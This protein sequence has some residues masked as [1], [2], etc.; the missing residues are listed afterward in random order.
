MKQQTFAMAADQGAGFERYRRRTKREDFLDAM[1]VIV[2]W[3]ALREVVEPHY[4]GGR[5]RPP[6]H[7]RQRMLALTWCSTGS[8]WP[9]RRGGGSGRHGSLRRFV[10]IDFGRER[11]PTRPRCCTSAACCES[12]S[13]AS[14]VR[15]SRPGA[16]A[17]WH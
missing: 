17:E 9:T 10:G 8:T 6:A 12:T 14:T 4:P 3:S 1:D 7:G 16:G 11:V 5:Q 2:P 15:R 13:W